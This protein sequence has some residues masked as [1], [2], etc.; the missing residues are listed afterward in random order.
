MS[1]QAH[2]PVAGLH[3]TTSFKIWKSYHVLSNGYIYICIYI[4]IYMDIYIYMDTRYQIPD[5][6][7][8]QIVP[9]T[10]SCQVPDL[11]GRTRSC[12]VVYSRCHNKPRRVK[13]T[14]LPRGVPKKILTFG[15]P[16]IIVTCRVS[17]W[18]LARSVS[19]ELHVYLARSGTWH[20]LVPGTIWYLARSG[21]GAQIWH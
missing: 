20:D 14:N 1:E 18:Y 13:L 9:G 11:P 7:R 8:Y 2:K 4:W 19:K 5:R 12:Q 3:A 21:T 10:R 17:I 15:P 16:S 6:A